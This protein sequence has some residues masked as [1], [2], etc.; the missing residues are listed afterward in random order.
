MAVGGIVIRQG[1]IRGDF[2]DI[3]A[4][5]GIDVAG[6][7]AAVLDLIPQIA[8]GVPIHTDGSVG[9]TCGDVLDDFRIVG[10]LGAGL[11]V[12]GG[13]AG[14]FDLAAGG[15]EVT[16]GGVAIFVFRYAKI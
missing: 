1:D 7:A 11:A 3:G 5:A 14:H 13:A 12:H 8:A 16:L 9:L 4:V 2:L 15:I 10:I 6:L